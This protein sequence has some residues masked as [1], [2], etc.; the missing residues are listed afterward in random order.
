MLYSSTNKNPLEGK[1][2]LL[3]KTEG[4]QDKISETV[5]NVVSVELLLIKI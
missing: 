2:C 1:Y 3:V 5:F 4:D